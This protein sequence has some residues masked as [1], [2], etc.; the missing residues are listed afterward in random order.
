MANSIIGRDMA[1][2]LG[3]ANTLVYVRGRGIMLDEPSVVA[4]ND[5]T[6]EILAVGH[7]AKRMIGRTPDNIR[8]IRPMKDGV[9]ADFEATEQMLRF[10]IQQVHRRRYFTKPRMVICVPSGITAVEQ[11]AVKEAGYQAG[12]RKVYII[13]EPMAA[14]IG[15]GLP[16][17]KA[18]GNMVVDVGGG[19]TEVAVISLGGVVTS[20]SIRTAGDDLDTA[21]VA[22]MKKEH[23]LM[24]GE[25]TAEEVKMTLGSAFPT[26]DEPEAEI[27]GRDM[28]SGLPRSVLVTS[29]DVRKALEEPLHAIVDAV[30]ATLDQTPPE[31][32]GDIMDRGIVL[33]GGGAL[34][35][36][37][38]E[39]LRHETGMPVHVAE[40]PLSSVAM[41]AGKCVEEFEG[42]AAGAG[43]GASAVLMLSSLRR[44]TQAPVSRLLRGYRPLRPGKDSFDERADR[45]RLRARMAALVLASLTLM[46]LDHHPRLPLADRAGPAGDGLGVRSGGVGDVRGGPPRHRDRRLVPH[47]PLPAERHR[48]PAGTELPA[49]GPGGDLA[50]HPPSGGRAPG[51]ARPR[52]A[53]SARPSSPLMSS[54]TARPSRSRGR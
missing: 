24:L 53:R 16:V 25:R 19:T 37:L 20:L 42:L 28:V 47:A 35:R 14:A 7:E 3:T 27:R 50:V 51:A 15:A 33:T 29:S 38:D 44:S 8:A 39:R 30:R 21:I 23:G 17:H 2:D 40:D 12:A 48:H 32:A 18:A 13:E 6:G 11:R 5:T 36:G 1:V 52:P 4:L 54:P 9:I 31:L 26:H 49:P 46:T 22:W 43:L 41:G 45:S 10:F 34:L